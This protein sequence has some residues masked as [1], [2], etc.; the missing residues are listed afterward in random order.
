MGQ[1]G[2]GLRGMNERMRQL[3]GTLELT[4]TKEGTIVRAMV[5]AQLT[6]S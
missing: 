1:L 4:S 6:K 3:G 2:V 5:P